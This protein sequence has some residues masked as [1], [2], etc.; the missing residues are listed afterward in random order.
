VPPNLKVKKDFIKE[1]W[2]DRRAV[3]RRVIFYELILLNLSQIADIAIGASPEII[4][5]NVAYTAFNC[6]IGVVLVLSYR[7]EAWQGLIHPCVVLLNLR[8]CLRLLDL[9]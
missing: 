5:M 4:T 3:L 2:N 1:F 6:I 9:E 8:Y 7:G